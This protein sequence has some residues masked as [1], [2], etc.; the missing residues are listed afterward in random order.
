M[1]VEFWIILEEMC[2][3]K[4]LVVINGYTLPGPYFYDLEVELTWEEVSKAIT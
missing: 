1:L 2:I 3:L 4:F